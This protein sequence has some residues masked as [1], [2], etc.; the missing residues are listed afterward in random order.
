MFQGQRGVRFYF[1]HIFTVLSL[2]LASP[3]IITISPRIYVFIY[4]DYS[5]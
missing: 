3:M 4:N 1:I 2:I 5:L